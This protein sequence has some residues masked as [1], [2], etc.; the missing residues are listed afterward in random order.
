MHLSH[1][2]PWAN[3]NR[4][5]A[6]VNR[7]VSKVRASYKVKAKYKYKI[8]AKYRIK[9]CKAQVHPNRKVEVKAR[10]MDKQEN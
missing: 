10:V 6:K 1:P 9:A 3:A 7:M 8:K 2:N 5:K 4:M